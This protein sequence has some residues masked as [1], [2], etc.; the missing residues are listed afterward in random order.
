M[1]TMRFSRMLTVAVGVI[2]LAA[3]VVPLP[4]AAQRVLG[5]AR[6]VGAEMPLWQPVPGGPRLS[7]D[8]AVA[9]G[10]GIFA[11]A[12]VDDQRQLWLAR[13]DQ[14]GAVVDPYG[15]RLSARS[16]RRPS[17]AFDGTNF[18][19]VW[20][21]SSIILGLRIS[22]AGAL[23][24]DQP[25]QISAGGRAANP[26]A[27]FDGGNHLVVWTDSAAG[28]AGLYGR[29]VTPAG[30][31]IGPADEPIVAGSGSE[32]E[33]DVAFNGTHHYL[34]WERT[35]DWSIL[36]ALV[37]TD[38]V[39]GPVQLIAGALL[40]QEDPVVTPLGPGFLVVWADRGTQLA[41]IVGTRIAADGTVID[42]PS[43]RFAP[44]LSHGVTADVATDG[45]NA[46]VT[47]WDSEIWNDPTT[48]I[49]QGTRVDPSGTILDPTSPVLARGA[50]PEL[51]YGGG[52]FLLVH[53]SAADSV[54]FE[55]SRVTASL[56]P[57]AP[58]GV[59]L[60]IGAKSQTISDMVFD[61]ANHFAVWADD[62]AGRSTVFGS[63]VSA[64]G[65]LLDGSG[66][67][68]SA[69]ST[70][71]SVAMT[72]PSV[73][74][75]G[76]TFLVVWEE[77]GGYP[78]I[79]AARVDRSGRVLSRF[80]VNA[81]GIFHLGGT[82]VAFGNGVFLVSWTS[83]AGVRGAR[84]D[85]SGVVL[86]PTGFQISRRAGVSPALDVAAG[87]SEFLVTWQDSVN[88]PTND[89]YAAVVTPAGAVVNPADI[90]LSTAPYH[91]VA[92]KVA[93]QNGTYLVVW[94]HVAAAGRIEP[95][96][97]SDIHGARVDGS[98]T[99]LDPNG[100]LISTAPNQQRAPSVA[101]NGP[102]LVTWTDR[103]RS[104]GVTDNQADVYAT[105]VDQDGTVRTELV[106]SATEEIEDRPVA[107]ALP[108]AGNFAVGYGRFVP[109]APVATTQAFVR[110]ISPK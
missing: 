56:D 90:P 92:P 70:T 25:I 35:V 21:S 5:G 10:A 75:D 46:V 17:I 53:L 76:T 62:R 27:S 29:R 7:S 69:S 103:R 96:S 105:R 80:L 61:G 79:R 74:F 58:Q 8:Q 19:V 54:T 28:R 11:V 72:N 41:D 51:A 73:A 78:A 33:L 37:T 93:W 107:T 22:P 71:P 98:G 45:T 60:A 101:A 66:I 100:L 12:W 86:D 99:V 30:T 40:P 3:L 49:L 77:S 89:L 106:V 102:F 39:A 4:T 26:E 31:I 91:Q 42:V 52:D 43:I 82:S 15:V 38:G 23:L 110:Q 84:I 65:R 36:G 85:K 47:W 50:Q 67:P 104:P 81:R 32:E 34:V 24:D 55:T 59:D 108:G 16:A 109:E 14:S 2:A 94:E 18:L 20:E 57:I 95:G 1:V 64:D 87:S 63:R 9:F 88:G 83:V 6:S 97:P 44:Y 13:V 68:I 48:S